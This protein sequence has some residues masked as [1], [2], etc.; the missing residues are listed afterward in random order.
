M[1]IAFRKTEEENYSPFFVELDNENKI[2]FLLSQE[3]K[4]ASKVLAACIHEWVT[5]REELYPSQNRNY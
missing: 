5:T 4:E 3:D 1:D 2:I